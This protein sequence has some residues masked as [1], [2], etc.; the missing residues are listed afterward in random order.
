VKILLDE[1][2]PTRL[3]HLFAGHDVATVRWIG[4]ASTQNGELLDLAEST[5]FEVFLTGDQNLPYQQNLRQRKIGIVILATKDLQLDTLES[6]K[7]A[8]LDAVGSVQ[9]G[10]VLYV[11]D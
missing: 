7:E 4:W 8:I 3:R 11:R 2:L 6:A 10:E 9:S 1:G 5:G